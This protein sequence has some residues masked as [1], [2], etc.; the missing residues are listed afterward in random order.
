MNKVKWSAWITGIFVLMSASQSIRAA[1]PH[2][3]DQTTPAVV[4][5]CLWAKMYHLYWTN[6]SFQPSSRALAEQHLPAHKHTRSFS[7]RLV[8][9]P[10]NLFSSQE[11][12]GLTNTSLPSHRTFASLAFRPPFPWYSDQADMSGHLGP[13]ILD[14][15]NVEKVLTILKW[16]AAALGWCSRTDQRCNPAR[17]N[18]QSGMWPREEWEREAS[19]VT[20]M[21]TGRRDASWNADKGWK[22]SL[23]TRRHPLKITA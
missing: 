5:R 19:N 23:I 2:R 18:N 16:W 17:F 3:P 13:G 6:P 9:F 11:S 8:W 1:E 14:V 15:I 12:R 7:S 21:Q 20:G 4:V 22:V 10:L